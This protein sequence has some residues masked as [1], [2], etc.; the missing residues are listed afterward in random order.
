MY[1]SGLK[2][3]AF[4]FCLHTQ[5]YF[6]F[7]N[8]KNTGDTFQSAVSFILACKTPLLEKQNNTGL[9][10]VGLRVVGLRDD[11]LRV[12]GLRVVGFVVGFDVG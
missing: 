1:L 7:S 11:G 8:L 10:V 5:L 12:D 9:F 3:K 2:T 6:L 4:K